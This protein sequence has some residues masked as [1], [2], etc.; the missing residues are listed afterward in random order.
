MLD[1]FITPLIKPV[2]IPCVKQLHKKGVSA[3]QLT[4]IGFLIGLLAVPL[5]ILNIGMAH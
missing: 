1:K 4:L 2:L 3:D 5:I